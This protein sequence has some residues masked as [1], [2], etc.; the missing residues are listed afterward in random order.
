MFAGKARAYPSVAKV[1]KVPGVAHCQDTHSLAYYKKFVNY[2]RKKFYK[3]DNLAG[4]PTS[5][6]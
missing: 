3:I 2:D 6:V 4:S 5:P 1:K